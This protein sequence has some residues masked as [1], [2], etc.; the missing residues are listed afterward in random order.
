LFHFIVQ[1]NRNSFTVQAGAMQ[2]TAGSVEMTS[3]I[4]GVGDFLGKAIAAKVT[5]ESAAKPEYSGNSLLQY[6]FGRW[7]F[8]GMRIHRQTKCSSSH[9][10][11]LRSSLI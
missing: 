8:P 11:E 3:G 4:K 1:L 10:T 6:G 7:P 5:K 9:H 2:W